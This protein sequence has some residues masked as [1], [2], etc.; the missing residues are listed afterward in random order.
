[1]GPDQAA[2]D[3]AESRIQPPRGTAARPNGWSTRTYG[4]P[5]RTDGPFAWFERTL[6]PS[7]PSVGRARAAVAR[8]LPDD[9]AADTLADAKLVVSE[10]VA[11]SV[12]HGALAPDGFVRVRLAVGAGLVRLEVEDFGASGVV[13]PRAPDLDGG[14]GF[15][16]QIVA[17]LARRWGIVQ[18]ASTRVW[19]E[20]ASTPAAT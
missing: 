1:M 19:V 6:P 8:W 5:E 15:G 4:R 9:V 11:N 16:L 10:L 20:L 18:E 3:A 17:A 12:R 2:L 14:G 13:A 7:I